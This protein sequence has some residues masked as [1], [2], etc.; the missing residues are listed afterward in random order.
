MYSDYDTQLQRMID[1]IDPLLDIAPIHGPSWT[2]ST[3]SLNGR[4]RNWRSLKTLL[5]SGTGPLLKL[6]NVKVQ[7]QLL[8]FKNKWKNSN[9]NFCVVESSFVQFHLNVSAVWVKFK[10]MRSWCV[11]TFMYVAKLRH[12]GVWWFCRF[13]DGGCLY[14]PP[15]GRIWTV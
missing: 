10:Y 14:L 15:L 7:E 9:V 1:A 6:W 5:M 13:F 2:G 12:G 11:H 3:A 4:R 8:H